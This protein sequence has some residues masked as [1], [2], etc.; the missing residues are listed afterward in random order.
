MMFE[1]KPKYIFV[2][3]IDTQWCIYTSVKQAVIVSD[4]GLLPVRRQAMIWTN[5]DL[6]PIGPWAT[7]FS[8]I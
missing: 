3:S 8:E 2:W 6:L 5:A 1:K 7:N 4:N